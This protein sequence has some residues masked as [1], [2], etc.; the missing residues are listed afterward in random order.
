MEINVEEWGNAN[1]IPFPQ[2]FT[3]RAVRWSSRFGPRPYLWRFP[4]LFLKC[5]DGHLKA[6]SNPYFYFL[7]LTQ[8]LFPALIIESV[9]NNEL[10]YLKCLSQWFSTCLSSRHTKLEKEMFAKHLNVKKY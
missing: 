6:N 4:S 10:L 8:N 2:A 1:F 3:G 5:Y 9:D 7:S